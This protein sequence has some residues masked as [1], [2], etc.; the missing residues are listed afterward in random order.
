[1]L[2]SLILLLIVLVVLYWIGSSWIKQDPTRAPYSKF[3]YAGLG[4]ILLA[5][6]IT[7]WRSGAFA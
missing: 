5:G 1:M 2:V 7:M 3:L 6:L 4:L